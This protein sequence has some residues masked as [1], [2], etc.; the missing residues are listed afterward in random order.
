MK[1]LSDLTELHKAGFV[2][3]DIVRPSNMPGQAFDNIFLTST[4]FRLID[5]GVSALRL[6]VNEKLFQRFVEQELKEMENFRTY[7]LS[8]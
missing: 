4:G 3:R 6:T 5:V 7:L 1:S 2:H 8:R